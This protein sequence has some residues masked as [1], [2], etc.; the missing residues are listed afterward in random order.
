MDNSQ[1]LL[2]A[3]A[4][5]AAI[6]IPLAVGVVP[7]NRLYGFRTASLLA[8]PTDWYKVNRF[9]GFAILG[10]AGVA[11][12]LVPYATMPVA[13]MACFAGPFVAAMIASTIYF[14]RVV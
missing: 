9:A 12:L 13:I 1:S 14:R 8:N 2:V 3:C 10:G 11:A 5:L 4:T 6:A 7:P